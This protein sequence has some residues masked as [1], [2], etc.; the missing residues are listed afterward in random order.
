MFGLNENIEYDNTFI[1]D[2][3]IDERDSDKCIWKMIIV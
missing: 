2:E 1:I 3:V